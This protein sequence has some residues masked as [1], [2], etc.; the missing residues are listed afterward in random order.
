MKNLRCYAKISIKNLINNLSAIRSVLKEE[1]EIIPII[2]ADAYSNG[3]IPVAKALENDIKIFAVAEINEAIQL[4]ENGIKNDIL[5]LGYTDPYFADLLVENDFTQTVTDGEYADMLSKSITKGELKIHVK[6]DTGMHR[7]GF[8]SEDVG[9]LSEVERISRLPFL[10]LCGTFS[11]FAESDR[12]DSGFTS[13][14]LTRFLSFIEK[15][16]DRKVDTGILHIANSAATLT[17]PDAHLMAVRP[18]IILYGAYPSKEIKDKYLS[19]SPD[20]PLKEVMTLCSRVAQ[21]H[22]VRKGEGIGYSR[23]FT[24]ERDTIVATISAGYA[25]GIP[26]ELSNKGRVKIG[27]EIFNIVGNVCMDLL[28]VD[29]T[30]AKKTIKAGDEVLFWGEDGISIDEYAEKTERIN[31]TIYTDVSPRVKRIY[32]Y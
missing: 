4:R 27:G 22:K 16:K 18:G 21:V 11:H 6:L 19:M 30:D 14:Q 17:R 25:D 26:R 20:K 8:D 2:K 12:L 3:A 7:F 28:M 13:L 9:N 23:A 15:L 24:A 29:I 5:I 31:Y 32:E 1:C 10:K